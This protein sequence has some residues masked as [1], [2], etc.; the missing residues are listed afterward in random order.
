MKKLWLLFFVLIGLTCALA[1]SFG[2]ARLSGVRDVLS[3]SNQEE[4]QDI[5]KPESASKSEVDLLFEGSIDAQRKLAAAIASIS[6]YD[7]ATGENHK[8]L[9]TE[10]VSQ[11]QQYSVD[12]KT[13]LVFQSVDFSSGTAVDEPRASGTALSAYFLSFVDAEA[14]EALFTSVSESQR[15]NLA[16]FVG[17]KEYPKG[18]EGPSDIDSGPLT[19]GASPSATL[20]S[21]G[22]PGQSA[23]RRY[24]GRFTRRC[25]SLHSIREK[26]WVVLRC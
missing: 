20:F 21:T 19:L 12:P 17:I 18:Q 11:F 25:N 10:L 22:E 16:G 6:L 7:K 2:G 1:M 24:I 3:T 13:G 4:T 23:I 26:M 15:V 8:A 14:L 5:S 9:L